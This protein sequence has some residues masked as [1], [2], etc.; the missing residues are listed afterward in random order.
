[1][2][3]KFL[4]RISVILIAMY[5]ILANIIAQFFFIDVMD[6]SYILLFELIVVVYSF[7][8]G[9][10]HCAYLKFTMLGIFFS[11]LITRLDNYFNFLSVS[12]HNAFGICFIAIGMGVSIFKALM[13]F[14][15]VGKL[16]QKRKRLYDGNGY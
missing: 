9:R 6:D 16:R 1:M 14:Y 12:E 2:I 13:H 7:S 4:V 8:E 3:G 5:F 10:Y 11:E 15:K